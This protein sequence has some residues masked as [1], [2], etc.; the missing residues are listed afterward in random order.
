MRR[1][2]LVVLLL[3]AA[4]LAV[5][6]VVTDNETGSASP[7]D[8]GEILRLPG[9]DLNV[10]AEGDPADPAVVLLHCFTCSIRWWE[11][12][13]R[14]LAADHRVI[15][16]DLL[17]HGG[18]DKPKDGY[19]MQNQARLVDRALDRLGVRRATVA[20]HSMG[21]AVATAL[22]E[23]SRDRLEGV[24]IV[25]TNP[26][27]DT[28][29]LPLTARIGFWPVIGEAVDRVVPDS[30]VENELG[31]AFAP[32]F[33]TPGY[34]LDDFRRLTY[35][36]YDKSAA[37]GADFREQRSLS[38]RLRATRLPVLVVLGSEDQIVEVEGS[39][40][41][42]RRIPRARIVQLR[43]VGHSPPVERPREL[44]RLMRAFMR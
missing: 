29:K 26:T 30:L 41:E 24:V 16:I 8:G 1:A 44:A 38:D 21:G 4:A 19:S 43:G 11:A 34:A 27:P 5:N 23:R 39:R 2:V 7:R 36:A 9:A 25:D 20:G 22:A 14:D 32:G 31:D 17:G 40:A 15:R 18:S 6:T 13:A 33:D 35:S 42:Y 10:S 3:L 28:G 37:E 12:V